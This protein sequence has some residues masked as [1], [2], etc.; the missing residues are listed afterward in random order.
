MTAGAEPAVF[1]CYQPAETGGGKTDMNE[2]VDMTTV[3]K[4]YD[5]LLAI[6]KDL[7]SVCIAF[8]G[9]VDSS[10][11]LAAARDAL[12]DRV[13]AVT[14]SAE[15]IAGREVENAERFAADRGVRHL[16]EPVNA[17][18]I[19]GFG[20]NPPDRCYIC[21]KSIFGRICSVAGEM[22][23]ESVADG[24][25]LDDTGDYRPGIRALEEMGIISPLRDAGFTKSD[26]R[27]MSREMNLPTHD[28]PS[29]ACLA[30]RIAYGD[31]ITEDRLKLVERGE[32]ALHEMGFEK[33]RLRLVV[34]EEREIPGEEKI[35]LP[36]Y[37]L[38]RIEVEPEKFEELMQPE[39]RKHVVE[40]LRE[41]GFAYVTLDLQG[42]RTGSMNE[43]LNK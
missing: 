41:L 26:I 16:T 24:T 27:A 25:N 10:F 2:S 39:V 5:K 29:F 13:L 30:S 33:S 12:G 9:G 31:L 38:A 42:F 40:K 43:V 4:K 11:L 37:Y 20:I 21:K 6:L 1:C 17:L 34:R 36:E 22:G 7:G 18:E 14:V 15:M 3:R 8:S 28:M 19:P 32:E 35:C 23:F